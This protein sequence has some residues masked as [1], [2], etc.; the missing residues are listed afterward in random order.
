MSGFLPLIETFD[1]NFERKGWLRDFH[2]RRIEKLSIW[3]MSRVYIG[4]RL[5]SGYYNSFNQSTRDNEFEPKPLVVTFRIN[6]VS[7]NIKKKLLHQWHWFESVRRIKD[8]VPRSL[9]ANQNEPAT[10]Y[11]PVARYRF[12]ASHHEDSRDINECGP[13]LFPPARFQ[14]QWSAN[15]QS[16][17]LIR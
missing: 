7:P 6:H 14:V 4:L 8:S 15:Q 9:V 1:K 10:V 12:W 17:I 11:R 16:R 13:H 5:S 3:K 2:R